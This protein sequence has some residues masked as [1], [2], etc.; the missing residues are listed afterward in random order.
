MAKRAIFSLVLL[1][2]CRAQAPPATATNKSTASVEGRVTSVSGEPLKN[3]TLRLQMQV[4]L[5]APPP[6]GQRP[7]PPPFSTTT[8]DASG[9]FKF[10]SLDPGSY[11]LTIQ[12]TGY[13][14]QSYNSQINL[15]SGQ[16]VA[17]ISVKLT[18]E[19]RIEGKVTNEDGEAVP[20]ARVMTYRWAPGQT[21][22]KEIRPV[23]GQ[24]T[25]AADGSFVIGGLT[26]GHY[27]VSATVDQFGRD[28][29]EAYVPAFYPGVPDV[30]SATQ[31]EISPGSIARGIDF[32]VSKTRIYHV[33]GKAIVATTGA[34]AAGMQ[35][36]PYGEDL[37]AARGST[38][39]AT[40]QEDGTFDLRNVVPGEYVLRT[41]AR[42]DRNNP[43]PPPQTLFSSQSVT[44]TNEDVEDV[45]VRLNP[46]V[47]IAGKIHMEDNSPLPARPPQL[48]LIPLAPTPGINLARPQN[49]DGVTLLYRDVPPGRYFPQIVPIPQ[50]TYVKSIRFGNQEISGNLIDLT[51]G[52]GGTLEI[53]L[54]PHA[55][56]LA[57][58]VHSN[59]EAVMG[60]QVALWASANGF[61]PRMTQIGPGG[62]FHFADLPP[63]EYHVA[64][65]SGMLPIVEFLN[66]FQTRA[67]TVR[68]EEDSHQTNIEAPLIRQA[69]IDAA[70]A[71]LR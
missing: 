1:A 22:L 58:S 28:S 70:I 25:A 54:S 55:A 26:A 30:G 37:G 3:A 51:S 21:G 66:Q 9:N 59:G 52:A 56:D 10:E 46:G 33:R 32:R 23:G 29:K 61:L 16:P 18:P 43:T 14:N 34:A 68:L 31:V 17:S 40:V 60:M 65:G 45:V 42:T 50:G 47:E 69:V 4:R 7:P 62:A 11:S 48:S 12:R 49:L 19:G 38:F 63:G 15:A 57:G 24:T 6:A 39:V 8:S 53:V 41:L 27:Y 2:I 13:L 36:A 67:A 44:V 71:S 20:N 35:I 64:A 5:A